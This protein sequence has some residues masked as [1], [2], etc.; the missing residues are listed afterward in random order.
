MLI[1]WGSIRPLS[2]AVCI[3]IFGRLLEAKGVWVRTGSRFSV[4]CSQKGFSVLK[5][6][7]SSQ[8]VSKVGS[9][10][11]RRFSVRSP[12]DYEREVAVRGAFL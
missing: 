2:H 3:G 4:E 6:L 12:K 7:N 10:A 1:I 11:D 8:R 9:G 5:R